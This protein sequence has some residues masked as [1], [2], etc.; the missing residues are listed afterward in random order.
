MAAPAIT[1]MELTGTT[2]GPGYA[3]IASLN[4]GTVTANAWS[5][6]QCIRPKVATNSIQSAEWWIYD[7]AGLRSSASV[8]M[9]TAGGFKHRMTIT[10]TYVKPSG[11]TASDTWATES[12]ES[13][14]S[15]YA[16]SAVAPGYGDFV[17]LAV[18]VNS[19][20]GDGAH[21][22]WGYQ[23]KYSYT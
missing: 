23:L 14:G 2:S 11:I 7:T 6:V 22:L 15:G 13:T 16:Y 1:W 18:K 5:V 4:F 10:S 21:T 9:G 20:A 12:P 19:S 3:S 8:A 17:Y